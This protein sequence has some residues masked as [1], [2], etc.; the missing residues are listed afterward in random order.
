MGRYEVVDVLLS[1]R[2][3]FL[4][5][6]SKFLLAVERIRVAGCTLAGILV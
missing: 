5:S 3:R 6:S 4:V 1:L 2:Q